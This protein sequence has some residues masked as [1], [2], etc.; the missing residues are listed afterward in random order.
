[1]PQIIEYINFFKKDDIKI[2]DDIDQYLN[3]IYGVIMRES[4]YII[5]NY[6]LSKLRV[7]KTK[8]PQTP[9]MKFIG[10]ITT[11]VDPNVR[12]TNII[13][14][15]I[16]YSFG[17]Y[18]AILYF[19]NKTSNKIVYD[20]LIHS[21]H[22]E[23]S[24]EK[25]RNFADAF[26]LLTLH[27][28][29]NTKEKTSKEI[30]HIL[31]YCL[32]WNSNDMNG[33]E[34]YYKGLNHTFNQLNSKALDFSNTK[35]GFENADFI[36]AAIK[37]INDDDLATQYPEDMASASASDEYKSIRKDSIK[38]AK[39]KLATEYPPFK[40]ISDIK[41]IVKQI[42]NK[43]ITLNDVENKKNV[44]VIEELIRS[45]NETLKDVDEFPIVTFEKEQ[46]SEEKKEESV[47]QIT[48]ENRVCDIISKSNPFKIIKDSGRT[49]SFSDDPSPTYSDCVE[50]TM[51][52][53]INLLLY[54]GGNKFD[55]D[56]IKDIEGINRYT[57][58]YYNAFGSFESQVSKEQKDIYGQ[59]L[60]SIDAW[61]YLIIFHANKNI[62]FTRSST[63]KGN[64]HK[65]EVDSGCMSLDADIKKTN[66][67][68]LLQNLL[69]PELFK[70]QEEMKKNI[71]KLNPR[72]KSVSFIGNALITGI[73][74]VVM[75]YLVGFVNYKIEID[76]SS[77]H[78][79]MAVEEYKTDEVTESK[80]EYNEENKYLSYLS[81]T[82]PVTITDENYLWFKYTVEILEE[83][84]RMGGII[85]LKLLEMLL[86]EIGNVD[87]RGRIIDVPV[88]ADQIT[89]KN[90]FTYIDKA[91][92][93]KV[94]DYIYS[95]DDFK[96]VG[97]IKN[98][99]SLNR[100]AFKDKTIE[101]LP[102]LTPLIR[103]TSIGNDFARSC[104]KL[105]TIDLSPLVNLTSIGSNF[106]RECRKL[107]NV[108]LDGLS[109][110]K[111][112]G[113][114]FVSGCDVLE[115]I[116]LSPLKKLYSIGNYF[117]NN[118]VKLKTVNLDGLLEL[119]TIGAGFVSGCDVLDTIDL[120][121]LKN[122]DSIGDYFASSCVKLQTVNLDGLV[123]LKSIGI[124]FIMN[125]EVLETIDLSPLK[126]LS[127][128]GNNFAY[129]CV[130]LK[131]V[132]LD[133]LLELK[134]IGDSFIN[135]CKVLDTIDLSPLKNL[136][137]IGNSF[138]NN[139]VNLQTV[140][141]D[142]L[143]GLKKI[144]G[145]R[146]CKVLETID[147]SPLKNLTSI[148]SGFA[149]N[150][151]K[152]KT[153]N[154]DGLLELKA[155][156]NEVLT[157][158]KVLETIDLSPLK[159]L[160]SIG[161]HFARNC[162]KLQTVN[163]DGLLELKTIGLGFMRGCDVLETIDL[164][165]LKNL[166]SIGDEFANGCGKLQTVNLDGLLEL[167]TIGDHFIYWCNVETIDL[168]PL[169]NLTSIGDDFANDCLKLQTVNLDGL[170][171]LKTIGLGFMRGCDVL[172]TIDLSHMKN[173][174]SIGD[175]FM[176]G[177]KVLKTI[178][179]SNLRHLV[180]IGSSFANNCNNLKTIKIYDLPE[181]KTIKPNFA[182]E[183][184]EL[185]RIELSKLPKLQNVESP[186]AKGSINL[187]TIITKDIP[188]SANIDSITKR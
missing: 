100:H 72:I 156:G 19:Y 121:P 168:S 37:K 131:T 118:C 149:D 92:N 144:D 28:N 91:T 71:K 2:Y 179:L 43:E 11:F 74:T 7:N 111:T 95:S 33:I 94:N 75:K 42:N 169:K 102:D 186:F 21:L 158:C 44:R 40:Q 63:L 113:A 143:V 62:T 173:L 41:T 86:S 22:E 70:T 142:G 141:L 165:P 148:A 150:C 175:D 49:K 124:G 30:F 99:T 152:L 146:G 177:C 116:D 123:E 96:F 1:M 181:L 64:E 39:K 79:Y 84:Y 61:S 140:N 56:L 8:Q 10:Q 31:L 155:I 154:L 103:L 160:T 153:V 170:V 136:D 106:A 81:G 126:K 85:Q 188:D 18:M 108:K 117:A 83:R 147:L 109:E 5:N 53:F 130:K 145:F 182:N 60:N 171:G 97:I 48:F 172:E 88:D 185:E 68:Q 101:S 15:I 9:E 135:D 167:K 161:K 73:G 57:L 23:E 58:E 77:D 50:T 178:E 93:V 157:R 78:S 122:L 46:Q 90:N 151:V 67:V 4:G 183:C 20:M 32:W 24:L 187:K 65:F 87:V 129:K 139:C 89:D 17:R 180:S 38:E 138:V 104:E 66:F 163:L 184:K 27:F 69:S 59:R 176:A 127:S 16:P 54:D 119:K 134:T 112:I 107:Q 174:D 110:L 34:Q 159:N 98:L 105:K 52:N 12:P 162:E 55:I 128:I 3:P 164:S 13:Q 133:G 25:S 35:L 51:R 26:R 82:P 45:V 76:F 137:S 114:G 80:S 125:C 132:N 115:T 36:K 29:P 120:S 14:D 47:P 166:T 6:Y